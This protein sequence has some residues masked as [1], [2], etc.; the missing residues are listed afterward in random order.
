MNRPSNGDLTELAPLPSSQN[1]QV[2]I[3][4][5]LVRLPR[6]PVYS[7]TERRQRHEHPNE[8]RGSTTDEANAPKGRIPFFCH[9]RIYRK[10][11][12]DMA[13]PL[14]PMETV[15]IRR[16]ETEH[17]HQRTTLLR[18]CRIRAA[19]YIAPGQQI[20]VLDCYA[21]VHSRYLF[22]ASD[23]ACLGKPVG[24]WQRLAL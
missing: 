4:V 9:K 6:H 11:C 22:T 7:P 21:E 20:R 16:L 24:A 12:A 1:W 17:F 19:A 14:I 13:D 18:S 15:L 5:Q 23:L 2:Q 10:S 3:T 8:T